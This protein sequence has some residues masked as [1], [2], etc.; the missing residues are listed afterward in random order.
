[1]ELYQWQEECLAAW[2]EHGGRGIVNVVTGAGKTVFA[3]AA[4]TR[5]RRKYPDLRVRIVVPVIP[6][7]NQ[8]KNDLLHH[9][10][11]EEW[12]PGFYGG[13]LKDD[14]DRRVMIYIINT[15]RSTLAGHIRREFALNH[16]VLLICDECHHT[17]SGENR[18][19][20][21]FLTPEVEKGELYYSL[22]LSATPFGTAY[23]HILVRSLGEEIY[24]YDV[25]AAVKAGVVSP[26]TVCEVSAS[27]LAEERE[28]YAEL[29]YEIGVLLRK[30]LEAYPSL[31]NLPEPQF[32]KK[33][34][35][36][37]KEADMDPEEPAA[38]FLLLT[39]QRKE[40]SNLAHARIQCAMGILDRISPKERVLVFCE[41]ISQAE[42][43]MVRLRRKAGQSCGLYHSKMTP[44][45]RTRV[46]EQY[47][48]GVLRILVS[49]R[50]LD[51]GI[52]V[53]DASV[54]IVLSSSAVGRQRT[55]RLGRV[56]RR[57]P[58]KPAACLYYIY[59]RE[60]TDDAAYLP[61]LDSAVTCGMRFYSAENS[62]SNDLYEYVAGDLIRRAQ[63]R[64]MAEDAVSELRKC[65]LEGLTRPDY[66]LDES[67]QIRA[68]KEADTIHGRNYWKTMRKVGEAFRG[69]D[70]GKK[71]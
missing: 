41:R 22:G 50:C 14:P 38:A 71:P 6:L 13:G 66:L 63:S 2:E 26:F 9:M 40:V 36:I 65:L 46:L 49:C 57:A 62:F 18:K 29:T 27:F 31:R 47:R 58:G 39:Y 44:E 30:L 25:N 56:I 11:D 60:S 68:E 19:I 28:Q 33:V 45:A 48:A 51:E 55:Q 69:S 16:P 15:A 3:M 24:R 64:G 70:P 34:T 53:P 52:D 5:L 61:G 42:E 43:L 20:Y 4:I 32:L 37:A 59:I 7:A 8:W 12:R 35:R 67:E 54:G 23:D 10:P 1:M 21:S 17:Q